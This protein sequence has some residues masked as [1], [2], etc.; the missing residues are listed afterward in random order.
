MSLPLLPQI[1]RRPYQLVY[2]RLHKFVSFFQQFV[3]RSNNFLF[4]SYL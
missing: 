2:Q 1:M 4:F 3:L